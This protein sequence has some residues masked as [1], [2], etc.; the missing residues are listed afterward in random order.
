[1]ARKLEKKKVLQFQRG[2]RR[3]LGLPQ[4]TGVEQ[5]IFRR[6]VEGL[7]IQVPKKKKKKRKR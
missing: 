1:M 6:L 4:P 5:G 3:G 7:G 2:L